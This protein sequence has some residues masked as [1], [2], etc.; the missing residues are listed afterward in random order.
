MLYCTMS[1]E[2]AERG[3][4]FTCFGFLRLGV[5]YNCN[6]QLYTVPQTKGFLILLRFLSI[7]QNR[8]CRNTLNGF[9]F[10]L[11][12][13]NFISKIKMPFLIPF[14]YSST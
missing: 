3:C 4:L 14:F 9:D 2:T 11:C 13:S 12:V 6:C 7:Q 10:F 1:L 8:M 5:F